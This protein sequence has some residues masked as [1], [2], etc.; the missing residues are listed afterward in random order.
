MALNFS[1]EGYL[2]AEWAVDQGIA[3]FVL[4]YRV[5][6]TGED[7]AAE[8]GQAV[9][10]R[11]AF[12]KRVGPIIPVA[13]ADGRAAIEYVRSHA[14]EFNIKPDRIGI[15]GFSAGGSVVCGSVFEHTGTSRPDF[16][17]PIYGAL[18]SF[19]QTPVPDDAMPLFI[20]CAADDYFGFQK[21]SVE[22]F[23]KWNAAGKPVEL[24]LY[25]KGG[26]GFGVRKQ[27]MPSDKWLN[28]FSEWLD[29]HG[30]LKK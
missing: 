14:A 6:P 16:A 19:E 2:M 5:A 1:N 27:G 23:N 15:A 12:L 20:V 28:A 3:A 22:L 11:E 29:N 18:Q 7:A 13:L 26:H 8:F 10:D 30:W 21:Q 17:A 9:G 4:K 24:H 25:E